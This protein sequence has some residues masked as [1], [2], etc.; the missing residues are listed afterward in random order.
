M[1]PFSEIN[2]GDMFSNPLHRGFGKLSGLEWLVME[3]NEKE[4]MILVQGVSYA[5]MEPVLKPI[6]KSNKDRM[7]SEF[8][9]VFCASDMGVTQ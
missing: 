3:K 9:R 2:V 1:M 8:W 5:T 7:F 6:W 4:K